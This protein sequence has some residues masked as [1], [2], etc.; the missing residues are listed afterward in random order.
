MPRG[1]SFPQTY[2]SHSPTPRGRQDLEP[3]T[4]PHR[5]RPGGRR[6]GSWPPR[7]LPPPAQEGAG[8]TCARAEAPSRPGSR[9]LR[10][11]RQVWTGACDSCVLCP[12][13]MLQDKGLS[14]SEEAFR[15][16]GAALGEASA[17]S[18]VNAANAPEPELSAPGL[19]GAALASPPGPGAD[20]AV[21]TAAAAEQVRARPA[22][23]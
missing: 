12:Q 15:A 16:P 21:A 11:P 3:R 10:G 13:E 1:R 2:S 4:N 18:A 7:I 22:V 5:S 6:K 14:E 9:G 8:S 19:S 20:V 23:S 17:A